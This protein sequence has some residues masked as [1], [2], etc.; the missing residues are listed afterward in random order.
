[1]NSETVQPDGAR[2]KQFIPAEMILRYLISNDDKTDTAIM[3]KE[4]NVVLYTSDLSLH[5]A[6]GSIK[7]NDEIKMNK[8]AKLFE[9]L[10]VFPFRQ[11]QKR[12][13][14]VLTHERVDKLRAIALKK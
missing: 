2:N 10:D 12:N 13:K 11:I 6:F 1:M 7:S 9:N 8:I 3:C 4:E 14:P 5:E